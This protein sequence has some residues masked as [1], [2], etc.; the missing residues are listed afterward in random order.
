[1]CLTNDQSKSEVELGL[2]EWGIK[3]KI[4]INEGYYRKMKYLG[5]MNFS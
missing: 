3:N 4:L 5:Y 1:M 2:Q